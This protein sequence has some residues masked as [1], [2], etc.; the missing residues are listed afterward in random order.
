M[1]VSCPRP[2]DGRVHGQLTVRSQD[3][4]QLGL[5][6]LRIHIILLASDLDS[7]LYPSD[8]NGRH[9]QVLCWHPRDPIKDVWW[10]RSRSGGVRSSVRASGVRS[11]TLR[12]GLVLRSSLRHR[13]IGRHRGFDSALGHILWSF[14]ESGI[15]QLPE[16]DLASWKGHLLLMT[17][18]IFYLPDWL[19]D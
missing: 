19:P 4:V 14:G 2:E 15:Q 10:R 1:H 11:N 6:I 17:H 13:S 3:F 5:Q 18:P 9:E 8:R 12:S 16:L 7:R